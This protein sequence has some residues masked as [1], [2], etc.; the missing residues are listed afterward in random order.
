M[1]ITDSKGMFKGDSHLSY[2]ETEAQRCE[3]TN[4]VTQPVYISP[5]C[6]V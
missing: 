2:E 3:V 5:T 4:T 1:F 6:F